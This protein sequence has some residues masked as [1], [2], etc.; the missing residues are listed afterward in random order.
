MGNGAS[1]VDETSDKADQ[2]VLV[3]VTDPANLNI[4]R[5]MARVIAQTDSATL[6]IY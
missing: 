4:S 2:E 3:T 1:N 6:V 5:N